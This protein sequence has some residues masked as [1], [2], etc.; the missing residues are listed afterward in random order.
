MSCFQILKD[1][2]YKLTPQR[3]MV[4]ETLH[5]TEGHIT[6]PEIYN[7]IRVK[8]PGINKST[9]YRTIELLK[10]INLVSETKL[11]GDMLHYHHTEKGHHHHLICQICGKTTDLDEDMLSPLKK[12]LNSKYSFEADLKHM[13]IWGYCVQCKRGKNT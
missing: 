13:A 5:E 3:M 11:D 2:G 10:E 6:A 12:T 7:R 9:V 8:Y 4:L 1:K